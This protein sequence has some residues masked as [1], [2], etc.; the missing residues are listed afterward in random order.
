MA[1]ISLTV[2]GGL[3]RTP[4]EIRS[5]V[6]NNN[7]VT[8][9]SDRLAHQ[10]GLMD[11]SHG[12]YVSPGLGGG[13][14]FQ[15]K[16]RISSFP[17]IITG[18]PEAVNTRSYVVYPVINT[19]GAFYEMIIGS[20]CFDQSFDVLN[21]SVND[22][23][24][25]QQGLK[26]S[27]GP[28]HVAGR[29]YMGHN[30]FLTPYEEISIVDEFLEFPTHGARSAR[31]IAFNR[32]TRQLIA[33][34]TSSDTVHAYDQL[35]QHLQQQIEVGGAAA[36]SSVDD[37]MVAVKE[38]CVEQTIDTFPD[39]VLVNPKNSVVPSVGQTLTLRPLNG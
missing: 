18:L 28:G 24:G 29:Y 19:S 10:L 21:F 17:M 5:L 23:E 12:V 33:V 3:L 34:Y 30:I 32:V 31:R 11:N 27:P 38:A 35:S 25:Y 4:V 22:R 6:A 15:L 14:P 37:I 2:R 16:W 7:H 9:I 1:N 36:A 26:P 20:D 13:G 8:Q 39:T